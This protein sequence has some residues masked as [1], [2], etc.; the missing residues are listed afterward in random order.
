MKFIQTHQT[1]NAGKF[2]IAYDEAP[3]LKNPN[4]FV[5]IYHI[6]S[7]S[8]QKFQIAL[9]A[10][11][12]FIP[13]VDAALVLMETAG[14]VRLKNRLDSMDAEGFILD[15]S[16]LDSSGGFSLHPVTSGKTD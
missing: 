12:A 14:L 16:G 7:P 13:D 10:Y 4:L 9:A 1:P 5:F 6:T 15:G 11:K 3:N 2:D 8:G